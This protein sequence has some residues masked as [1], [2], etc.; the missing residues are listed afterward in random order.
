[1]LANSL[2]PEDHVAL[3]ATGDRAGARAARSVR[4]RGG[5]KRAPGNH[6]GEFKIDRRD[7]RTLARLLAA[8]LLHGCGLPDEPTRPLRRRLARRAQLVR[9]RTRGKNEIHAVL[10]RNLKGAARR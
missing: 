6:R 2:G 8:G 1:M 3:E 10:M 7:A 5:Q 4:C 9:R